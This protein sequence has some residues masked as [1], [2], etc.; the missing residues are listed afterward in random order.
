MTMNLHWI[1]YAIIGIIALSAITGLI[2]GF[3]KEVVALGVWVLAG[4]MAFVYAKPVATWLGTYVQ[5]KSARV[6]LAYVVIIVGTLI[7]GGLLNTMLSFIMHHS[8]L[9]GTD[10]LLGLGF[11]A[12]RGIFI[13]ALIMVVIRLSAFPEE[14][15]R[16][17]AQFYAY[18]NPLVNWMYQY[19][20]DLLKRA[21]DFEHH[22]QPK[23][24]Q[25]ASIVVRDIQTL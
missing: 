11:G 18:F 24:E 19:T 3:I 15:Y 14:E 2:R 12:A 21:E 17:Q 7:I 9:T 8:G 1:D 5:D 20:P 23:Q 22:V 13:V 25:H 6:I 10:R 16:K 4:W